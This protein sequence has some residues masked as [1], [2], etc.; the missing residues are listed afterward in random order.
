MKALAVGKQV[1][2]V[3]NAAGR[4]TPKVVNGVPQT[5]FMG[6]GKYQPTEQKAAPPIRTCSDYPPDG[7][8]RIGSI[9]EALQKAGLRDG[10]TISSHHHFRDGDLLMAQ[11]F[12][13]VAEL[14]VKNVRWFP[15]ASFPCH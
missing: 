1:E 10:M 7:D 11:V 13:A 9:K 3:E 6:V 4:P 5:P 2:L 15:S 14:G 8:K 12:E